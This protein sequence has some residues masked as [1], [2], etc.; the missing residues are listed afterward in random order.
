[1]EETKDVLE[2]QSKR[3]WTKVTLGASVCSHCGHRHDPDGRFCPE[4]GKSLGGPTAAELQPQL[5]EQ[6]KDKPL[7]T[8]SS[9]TPAST[10]TGQPATCSCGCEL[11][12][13]SAFCR[14]CGTPVGQRPP[15]L[16]LVCESS[17]QHLGVVDLDGRD[18]TIGKSEDNNVVIPTDDYVSGRHARLFYVGDLLFMEDLASRNGTYLR[19]RRHVMLEAGDE[20][21]IGATLMRLE[22]ID[23]SQV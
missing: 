14:K 7:K 12:E 5:V 20:I 10:S 22:E 6:R 1:M 11:T 3:P 21:L 4:C 16:R 18:I 17:G 9:P 19:P 23:P 15:K 8:D 13:D 2:G